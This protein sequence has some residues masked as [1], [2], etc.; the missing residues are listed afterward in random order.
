MQSSVL[1]LW[2]QAAADQGDCKVTIFSN[3]AE[4]VDA[5]HEQARQ[6]AD[7]KPVTGTELDALVDVIEARVIPKI[8]EVH[9]AGGADAEWQRIALADVDN[10]VRA[11]LGLHD[12][13]PK[14]ILKQHVESGVSDEEICLDL[15]A[16][17]AARLGGDWLSDDLSFYQVTTGAAHLQSL[18]HSLDRWHYGAVAGAG[19]GRRVVLCGAPGEQHLFGL[20]MLDFF[21]RR[22]GWETISTVG[23]APEQVLNVLRRSPCDLV[24]FSCS[25]SGLLEGLASVIQLTRSESIKNDTN[26][27]V[28]GQLFSDKPELV[29]AVGSDAGARDAAEAIRVARSLVGARHVEGA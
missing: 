7:P 1:L 27:M 13:S 17:A 14:S 9:G 11:V 21:F 4:I 15:L 29:R 28:G 19:C 8:T 26:I 22:D 25:C 2:M 24:A 12:Q 18:L 20:S 23:L 6:L 10:L 3:S 16:P 5:E